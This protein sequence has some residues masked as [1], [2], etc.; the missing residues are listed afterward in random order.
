M[1]APS[2]EVLAQLDVAC[3][4]VEGHA[5][6]VLEISRATWATETRSADVLVVLTRKSL[7]L[8]GMQKQG[9]FK[10][11]TP[12]AMTLRLA[13]YNDLG[14]IEVEELAGPTVMFL[15]PEE[16]RHF[17]LSW[18]DPDERHRMFMAMFDAHRGNYARWGLQLDP[19]NY[20][21][22]F[23]R[24]YAQ[25]VGEGP[26][27]SS[28]VYDWVKARFGEFYLSN[29]LGLAMDWRMC[30]LDDAARDASSRRVG[31]IALPLPWADE[32]PEAQ[33]VIVRLGEQLFDAGLLGPPY[34]E[35]TYKTD[36]P[37][38]NGDTGPQRLLALMTLA[39]HAKIL[40]NPRA[41]EW[42]SAARI[43]IPAVPPSIFSEAMRSLWSSVEELPPVGPPVEIPIWED[44]DV[45]TIAAMEGDPP[46]PSYS[47]DGLTEADT[48]LIERFFNADQELSADGPPSGEAVT[49]LCLLGVSAFEG[50]SA[51]APAGW[52]KLVLYAVSDL[53]YNLWE[54]HKLNDAAT[55]L[56]HW[57]IATMEANGWAAQGHFTPLGQ[58]YTYMF[59]VAV[60][61]GA[62][63]VQIDP[64]TG[65]AKA[66]TGEDARRAA[67]LGQF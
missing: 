55:K 12:A 22:D 51:G 63:V 21:A 67:A 25:L 19:A 43:G 11:A 53:T 45:R 36:E 66:P 33:R 46:R 62:G 47:T 4:G 9:L 13:D 54:K 52:R 23:D 24:Y 27:Q 39:G 49:N 38:T 18:P 42:I 59:A 7:V 14:E 10:P 17:M 40:G 64:D 31:R 58:H 32:G 3:R 48:V 61:T 35:R 29:A 30:E 65:L 57:V 50:L 6:A 16:S 5:D 26:S 37:L 44:V 28:D 8:V 60:G 15:A 20:V 2:P 41:D 56:A 1:P 34:D